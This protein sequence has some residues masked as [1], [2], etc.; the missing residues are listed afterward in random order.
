MNMVSN[1][2]KTPKVILIVTFGVSQIPFL[3]SDMSDLW[4]LE[5]RT[6]RPDV[7]NGISISK[8]DGILYVT[9]KLWDRMFRLKLLGFS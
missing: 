3:F 4:P 5:N 8:D 7:L 1:A 2:W 9:G 6:Y